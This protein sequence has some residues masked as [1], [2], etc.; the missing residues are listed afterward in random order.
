METHGTVMISTIEFRY[1]ADGFRLHIEMKNM[2]LQEAIGIMRQY[3]RHCNR[4][5]LTV[6]L[7]DAKTDGN[8]EVHIIFVSTNTS[9]ARP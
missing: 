6:G 2:K 1:S 4:H 9:R 5:M 8:A 3:R 7:I